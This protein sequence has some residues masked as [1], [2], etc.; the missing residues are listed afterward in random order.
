MPLPPPPDPLY[1]APRAAALQPAAAPPQPVQPQAPAQPAASYPAAQPAGAAANGSLTP[2]EIAGIEA[3]L[4]GLRLEAIIDALD[5]LEI[6]PRDEIEQAFVRL[7][8]KRFVAEAT[9]VVGEPV[10]RRA[11]RDIHQGLGVGRWALGVGGDR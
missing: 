10:A 4:V 11:A 2:T 7:V 6:M 1:Q 5:R 8:Q 9:L 3:V